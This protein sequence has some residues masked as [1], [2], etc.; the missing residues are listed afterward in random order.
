M[1]LRC[2]ISFVRRFQG[3][4]ELTETVEYG[5]AFQYQDKPRHI[6]VFPDF[7]LY[8]EGYLPS[9]Y[10][11]YQKGPVFGGSHYFR[12]TCNNE[13]GELVVQDFRWSQGTG[14]LNPCKFE[15]NKSSYTFYPYS[16]MDQPIRIEKNE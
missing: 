5:A 2:I 6:F 4:E 3:L 13:A 11:L 14:V 16:I 9:A 8:Y 1:F 7:D 15:L 10:E 12:L